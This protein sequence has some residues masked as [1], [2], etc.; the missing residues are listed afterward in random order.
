[1]QQSHIVVFG[2]PIYLDG[3]TAQLKTV[4]DRIVCCMKPF[5]W[6]D[7]FGFSRHSFSLEFTKDIIA[8]ST[9]GFPEY[10][11]FTPLISYF[12]A[13]SKNL[14]SRLVTTTFIWG[15]IAIQV[16]IELLDFKI[17]TY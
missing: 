15:S 12:N 3:I 7:V 4:I 14:N 9:C 6:T 1:M 10:E 13:L 11:T 5:L 8:V 16:R 17:E 2:L